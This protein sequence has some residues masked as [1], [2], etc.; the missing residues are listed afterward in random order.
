MTFMSQNRSKKS[1]IDESNYQDFH[2]TGIQLQ[3]N[4]H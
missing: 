2:E 4:R 3:S 1:I